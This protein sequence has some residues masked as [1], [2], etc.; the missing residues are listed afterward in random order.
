[1]THT[2]RLGGWNKAPTSRYSLAQI[3]AFIFTP[4]QELRFTEM[5]VK[6]CKKGWTFLGPRSR[7]SLVVPALIRQLM[8]LLT[9]VVMLFEDRSAWDCPVNIASANVLSSTVFCLMI[10]SR[11]SL[12]NAV[13][14]A[15]EMAVDMVAGRAFTSKET[16]PGLLVV[17]SGTGGLI[18]LSSEN[19]QGSF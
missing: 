17:G 16:K 1:M 6:I 11:L 3:L 19:R 10:S 5:L 2:Y 13:F 15:F 18:A 4:T 7:E 14:T 12:D 8:L 9:A